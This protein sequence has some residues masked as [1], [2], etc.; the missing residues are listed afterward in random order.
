M[1]SNAHNYIAGLFGT[2]RQFHANEP[3]W[4]REHN[5]CD[6]QSGYLT[7]WISPNKYDVGMGVFELI[8]PWD[9]WVFAECIVTEYTEA[10]LREYVAFNPQ[11]CKSWTTLVDGSL[12][13][14]LKVSDP[15]MSVATERCP[16]SVCPTEFVVPE[17]ICMER[18]SIMHS[19]LE[20]TYTK[21]DTV[22]SKYG[23]QEWKVNSDLYYDGEY[24]PAYV[25]Y[26]GEISDTLNWWVIA[27]DNITVAM[28]DGTTSVYGYC[29]SNTQSP[30]NCLGCWN[31]YFSGSS[32]TSG[33]WHSDCD[34]Q[35]IEGGVCLLFSPS[36]SEFVIPHR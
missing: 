6:T 18:S 10:Q 35:M 28:E 15:T 17:E 27:M 24:V 26:Y 7:F 2:Y 30:T 13:A 8:D 22:G 20:G 12:D 36:F 9:D 19:F 31:F 21:T 3:F 11:I 4:F 33:A 1:H 14:S 16:L 34:F 25:W 23:T 32:D 29:A 5:E